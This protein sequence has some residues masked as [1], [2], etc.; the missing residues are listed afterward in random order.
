MLS[1]E[2]VIAVMVALAGLLVPIP[3][4]LLGVLIGV[5]QA[6]IFTML[7]TVFIGA[8]IGAIERG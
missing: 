5:I 8:A 3:F 1:H 4:M 2:I 7:A 6:F